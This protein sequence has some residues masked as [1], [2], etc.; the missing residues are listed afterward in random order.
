ME[1]LKK[2]LAAMCDREFDY[3]EVVDE[4]NNSVDYGKI[5]DFLFDRL[6]D[7]M[8]SKEG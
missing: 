5:V 3:F 1:E 4:C 8:R 6:A 2:Q 7:M